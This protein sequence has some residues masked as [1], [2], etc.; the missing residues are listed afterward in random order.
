MAAFAP[1]DLIDFIEED[2][3]GVFHAV[4]GHAGDLVHINQPLLFF[5]DQVLEGFVDLHLPFLGALAENVGQ[6]VLDVDVHLLD[7]LIRDDLEGRE[8]AF[9]DIDFHGALVELA[10]AQLLAKFFASAAL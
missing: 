2:D 4:D 7:A 3:A 9:A 8:I 6:H 5:L 10:F 1:G